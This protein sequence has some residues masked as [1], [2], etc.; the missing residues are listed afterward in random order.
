MD[1]YIADTHFGHAQVL[2]EC[3]PQFKSIDEMDKF[4]IDNINRKM[5]KK[6]TLYIIGD[7]SY[8]SKKSP[9]EY[10][11][12][13]KPKKVLILGNHDEW[14]KKLSEEEKKKYFINDEKQG[15]NEYRTRKNSIELYFCHYPRLA[16]QKS[17]YFGTTFSIC[18]HIHNRKSGRIDAEVFGNIK[19]Q[20][21]AG[22]DINN[23]EPVTFEELIKNNAEFYQRT[24]TDEEIAL[25]KDAVERLSK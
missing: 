4:I 6:D 24:Y 25:L 1:Y 11:E 3:R 19:N 20:F 7:F 17:Q 15:Y 18:G 2:N 21:N 9:T 5:T 14:F 16:W 12:A 10:L 22:V 13:I 8:R 23:F